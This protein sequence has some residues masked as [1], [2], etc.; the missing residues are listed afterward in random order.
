MVY[1]VIADYID[2]QQFTF[3]CPFCMNRHL[4]GNG[5]DYC[6]TRYEYRVSH[7]DN[8][9]GQFKIY[10]CKETKR[11]LNDEDMEIYNDYLKNLDD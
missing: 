10:I 1:P 8:Y 4:H 3:Q 6:S 7:C 5:D 11:K 9:K 2:R